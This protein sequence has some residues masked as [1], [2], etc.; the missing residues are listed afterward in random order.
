MVA[1]VNDWGWWPGLGAFFAMMNFYFVDV[2]KD[3][4]VGDTE[5][6]VGRWFFM[7]ALT[8]PGP[9]LLDG[10]LGLDIV[11]ATILCTINGKKGGT[12]I[13]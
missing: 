7:S 8:P 2:M 4:G 12:G 1:Y 11:P 3:E 6:Y 9:G 13:S 10:L 5:L